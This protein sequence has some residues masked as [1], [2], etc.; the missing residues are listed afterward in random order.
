MLMV[1]VRVAV[2]VPV[3][4]VALNATEEVPAAVG[5]PEIKPLVVFTVS[6][7]GSPV[8]AKLVGLL[9]AVI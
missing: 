8:A 6:P 1:R 3:P 9:L 5:I 7:E 2:A 4:L